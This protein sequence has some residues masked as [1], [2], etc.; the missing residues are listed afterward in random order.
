[1]L[2]ITRYLYETHLILCKYVL[3]KVLLLA[4]QKQKKNKWIN[5]L[6]EIVDYNFKGA[7]SSGR[8]TVG[9]SVVKKQ[10]MKEG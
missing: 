3:T 4:D 7:C 6:R 2:N 10:M 5:E 8:S 9:E 1:M